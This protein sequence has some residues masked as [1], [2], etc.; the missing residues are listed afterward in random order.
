[1]APPIMTEHTMEPD[2][3]AQNGEIVTPEQYHAWIER[4]AKLTRR[5]KWAHARV[6]RHDLIPNLYLFEAWKV[7]PDD[8]GAPRFA[9]AS[10]CGIKPD[11]QQDRS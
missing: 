7:K 1:M 9:L 11:E 8:E 5:R 10:E 3:I 4:N 6:T 2:F